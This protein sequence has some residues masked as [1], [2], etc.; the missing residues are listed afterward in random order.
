MRKNPYLIDDMLSSLTSIPYLANKFGLKQVKACKEWLANN[1]IDIY[2]YK[3]K[4]RDRYPCITIEMGNSNEKIEMKHLADESSETVT[5]VP[6]QIGKPIPY[7]V[8]P[9]TPVGYD[10]SA[11]TVEVGVDTDISTV[12]AGQILVDPSNGNGYQILEVLG[13][14]LFIQPGLIIKSSQ[15]GIV[16]QFQ[17]YTARVG[18]IFTQDT[19]NI[20]CHGNGDPQTTLW[21]W[22]IALYGILRYKETLFEALGFTESYVQNNNPD[23]NEAF[24]TPGGEEVWS[25][26]ITIT[27]QVEQTFLKSP[28]RLLESIVLRENLPDGFEGGIKIMSNL[29]S[30]AI[31]DPEEETWLT[32]DDD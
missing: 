8:K 19:Y 11:G 27:G 28:R 24:S 7:V 16:P 5:L 17:Y 22:S 30:P 2:M 32:V 4:D 9:F 13:K 12:V 21:L 15:F 31:L 25:R 1:Q 18:H 23:L 14:N 20:G 29:D 26:Y 6:N 10:P 3:R